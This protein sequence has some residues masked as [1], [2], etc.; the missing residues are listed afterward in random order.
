LVASQ[1]EEDEIKDKALAITDS[2]FQSTV[3]DG[4][5][6][7][8]ITILESPSRENLVNFKPTAKE[9]ASLAA[10]ASP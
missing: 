2:M 1:K 3:I 4:V 8:S 7:A 5:L 9:A 6:R 10:K